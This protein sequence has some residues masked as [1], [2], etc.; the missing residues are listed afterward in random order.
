[1]GQKSKEFRE[2]RE[3]ITYRRIN[4]MAAAKSLSAWCL[5]IASPQPLTLP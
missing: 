1:M 5:L 3:N 4:K 2:K